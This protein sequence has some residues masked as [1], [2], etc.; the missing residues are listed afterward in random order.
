[1]TDKAAVPPSVDDR[2]RRGTRR[3]SSLS[4]PARIG[5]WMLALGVLLGPWFVAAVVLEAV[6]PFWFQHGERSRVMV[7]WVALTGA[8]WWPLFAYLSQVRHPG[9]ED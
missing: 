5:M 8:I 2:A 3:R 1:M 9:E 6:A 4:I 7:T